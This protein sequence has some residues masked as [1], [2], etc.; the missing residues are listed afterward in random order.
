MLKPRLPVSKEIPKKTADSTILGETTRKNRAEKNI[1]FE[2]DFKRMSFI[3]QKKYTYQI[4]HKS[5]V[6]FLSSGVEKRSLKEV[7][8]FSSG[9]S[10]LSSIIGFL[11]NLAILCNSLSAFSNFLLTKYQRIDSGYILKTHFS[12]YH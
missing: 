3:Y 6:H 9:N 12:K 2:S 8:C 4:K 10:I 11:L 5:N 7:T 1:Q